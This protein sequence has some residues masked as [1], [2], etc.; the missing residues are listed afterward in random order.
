MNTKLIKLEKLKKLKDNQEI[1]TT[2]AELLGMANEQAASAVGY[3]IKQCG[4]MA[5]ANWCPEHVD[6][7][8]RLFDKVLKGSHTLRCL[9]RSNDN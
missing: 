9:R 6:M 4:E 1:I 5:E 2:K 7:L 8:E 3:F